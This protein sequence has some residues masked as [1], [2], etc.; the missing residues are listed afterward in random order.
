VPAIKKLRPLFAIALLL[1][2]LLWNGWVFGW[3]N[4]GLAG[5]FQMS[6]S[7]LEAAS[8][9][10]VSLFNSLENASGLLMIIGA[11]GLVFLRLTKA[12]PHKISEKERL[13]SLPLSI[14]LSIVLFTITLIGVLTLYDVAHPLDCNRYHNPVCVAKIESQPPQL[15][16]TNTLHET[17]SRIAAYTTAFLV[18]VIVVWAYLAK[19]PNAELA[20]VASI[21]IATIIAL[22]ILDIDGNVLAGAISERIWNVLVSL[23]IGFIALKLLGSDHMLV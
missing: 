2:A 8:Q 23:D 4:H 5:Y 16:H 7:E 15:S 6:I 1:G 13:R 12:T 9:P 19:L 17:E 21:A 11:L 10:H 3:L 18:L 14:I 22:T 20:G